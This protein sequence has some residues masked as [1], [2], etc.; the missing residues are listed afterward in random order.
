MLDEEES[1]TYQIDC[2]TVGPVLTTSGYGSRTLT[3]SAAHVLDNS[4]EPDI[5]YPEVNSVVDN[6]TSGVFKDVAK[7]CHFTGSTVSVMPEDK[8]RGTILSSFTYC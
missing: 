6:T 2:N 5:G 3:H 8:S 7:P 4:K 1:V